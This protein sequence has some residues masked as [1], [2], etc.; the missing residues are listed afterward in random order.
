MG[1]Y[2]GVR[3]KGYVKSQF[4]DNFEKIAM[5]GDWE[6]FNDEILNSFGSISR[7]SFIPCGCLSYMPDEW[8]SEPYDK[9]GFE[10]TWNKETGYWTFQC[11][12][13]N[14]NDTIEEWFKILP[15]FIENIEHLEKYYEGWKY[16][17][18]YDIV[19]GK[20]KLINNEFIKYGYGEE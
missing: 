5:D 1:D 9:Y 14:Y 19:N 2:T 10:R 11:S 7:A 4:R 15:Y 16:S 12:L 20:V 6:L 8:E 13:K 3:F 17:K 18:Q